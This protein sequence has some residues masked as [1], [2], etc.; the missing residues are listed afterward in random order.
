MNDPVATLPAIGIPMRARWLRQRACLVI[1]LFATTVGVAEAHGPSRLNA[2]ETIAINAAPAQVWEVIKDF[3]NAH[4]WL[5]MVKA[6][7]SKGGNEPG[8]QRVLSI[9][10]T[11]KITEVLKKYDAAAMTYSYK[12]PAETHDVK[13]LPVTN[14]TSTISVEPGAGGSLVTWR[15]AFYRGYPSNDPPPELND[16]AAEKA[17]HGLYKAGLQNLK[18]VVEGQ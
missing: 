5:P 17:V 2:T 15:A 7:E 16:D 14:Y 3:D 4:A 13:I 8:T 6:T 12:I 1:A 11:A 18:K 10:D 9:G